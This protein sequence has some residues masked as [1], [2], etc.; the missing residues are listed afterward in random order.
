MRYIVCV[1]GGGTA[2]GDCWGRTVI[3]FRDMKISERF[4]PKQAQCKITTTFWCSQGKHKGYSTNAS[5]PYIYPRKILIAWLLTLFNQSAVKAV[6][7]NLFGTVDWFR[8]RHFPWTGVGWGSFQDDS[9]ELHLG[10]PPALQ[11]VPD[12]PGLAPICRSEVEDPCFKE[13]ITFQTH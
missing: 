11:L 13:P 3:S 6:V 2:A 10:S 7:P 5:P 9:S 8:G 1:C 12:R 4:S